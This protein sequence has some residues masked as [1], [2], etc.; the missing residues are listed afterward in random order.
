MPGRFVYWMNVSTDLKIEQTAGEQGGGSWMRIGEQ[1]HRDFNARARALSVMV[2]GR[3][4]FETMESFWPA[5]RH[6]ES[7]DDYMREY[8]EIWTSK[9]KVLVSRTRTEA[10]YNT[11]V[12]GGDGDAVERLA[13]LRERTD[14][15]IGVGGATVATLLLDAG[16]LD[17]LLLFTH[18][19]V[20]GAGRPLFDG[21]HEPIQLDLLEHGTF[22]EGVTMHRYAVRRRS[23]TVS[24]PGDHGGD[25]DGGG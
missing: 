6:D 22:D 3:V 4:I 15:D 8:G 18:P 23:A 25:V 17:E 21:H 9:P 19:V 20:L 24:G 11:Q 2:Q 5:A 16:L 14:G 1:L 13:E 7:L 12:I 10:G